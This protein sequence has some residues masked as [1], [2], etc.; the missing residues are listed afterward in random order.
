MMMGGALHTTVADVGI[1]KKIR[2]LR[3]RTNP[4]RITSFWDWKMSFSFSNCF[5]V[6]NKSRMADGF[7]LLLI[8]NNLNEK[9][10]RMLENG[11]NEAHLSVKLSNDRPQHY[12]GF[13]IFSSM[14]GL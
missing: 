6:A 5:P 2:S 7:W 1:V 3:G 13:S 11:D 9:R 12:K 4:A 14:N 8:S 10:K